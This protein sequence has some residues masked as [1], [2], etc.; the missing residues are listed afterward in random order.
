VGT[1][2]AAFA[3]AV[4][5]S[6]L[7]LG[8][9]YPSDVLGGYLVATTWTMAAIA[10]LSTVELRRPRPVA[11]DPAGEPSVG[12]SLVPQ[13]AVLAGTTALACLLALARPHTVLAYVGDH[14]LFIAGA[15]AIGVLALML[16]GVIT[17]SA[18][19]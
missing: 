4:S 17:L 10:A 15:A 7:A 11:E 2:G 16:A 19:R 12:A 13:A 3:V 5:Y 9:H 8:W 1:A 18:R 6:F 14:L